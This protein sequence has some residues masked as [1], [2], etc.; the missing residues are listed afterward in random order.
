MVN[1]PQTHF[2]IF[3]K[4][5]IVLLS[6]FL[7]F[8]KLNYNFWIFQQFNLIYPPIPLAKNLLDYLYYLISKRLWAESTVSKL[9][10]KL[11]LITEQLEI[12]QQFSLGRWKRWNTF[13]DSWKL[14]S[15]Q[16]N[17]RTKIIFNRQKIE[18]QIHCLSL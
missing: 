15:Y 12:I 18:F 14:V 3:Q 2:L 5:G 10:N 16:K 4:S 17:L 7:S 11:F 1:Y 9:V 8:Q 13:C 6:N